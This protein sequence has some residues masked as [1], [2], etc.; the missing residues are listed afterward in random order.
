[1]EQ[2]FTDHAHCEA[3]S[4][5]FRGK[6][7]EQLTSRPHKTVA[8][9][10]YVYL[11][12][13][14]AISIYFLRTGLVK[15]SVPTEDGKDVLLRIYQT[16]E[17]FGEFC[18][19]AGT[20]REQAQAMEDSAIVEISFED[21]LAHLQHNRQALMQFLSSMSQ[22]LAGAYEQIHI[23]SSDRR[24]ERLIRT[25]LRLAHEMGEPTEQ[26]I[27]IE[28]ILTQDDLA[29][30]IAARREVTST[31][32]NQLRSLQ[33]IDYSRGGHILINQRGL[34]DYLASHDRKAVS[35]QPL[36]K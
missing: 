36:A 16:G 3:L 31:L 1:M 13:D 14:P 23:L 2:A 35:E 10:D 19:C 18:L 12:G 22:H 21:L 11:S 6:L 15:V 28:P 4:G 33:L 29:Q 7:C 20:S 25:L 34:E 32:L 26:G 24:M 17:I 5:Q 30:M 9:G 27:R 8:Q